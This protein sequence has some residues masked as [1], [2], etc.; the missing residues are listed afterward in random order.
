MTFPRVVALIKWLQHLKNNTHFHFV[1][2]SEYAIPK[3]RMYT[4]SINIKIKKT[5]N[6][7]MITSGVLHRLLS[8]ELNAQNGYTTMRN[9]QKSHFTSSSMVYCYTIKKKKKRKITNHV[10][11]LL[12]T[13]WSVK[14]LR[15][16][17][18][19]FLLQFYN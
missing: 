1:Y 12:W 19:R 8:L 6:K 4:H 10:H 15:K 2:L 18:E 5:I 17:L 13:N 16:L 9:C 7:E 3:I 11:F 14:L